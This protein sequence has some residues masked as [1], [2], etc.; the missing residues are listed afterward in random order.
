M[1]SSRCIYLTAGEHTP[2]EKVR[3]QTKEILLLMETLQLQL[4]LQ[5][6]YLHLH[7]DLVYSSCGWCC[8]CFHWL[9][10]EDMRHYTYQVTLGSPDRQAQVHTPDF[11]LPAE[12]TINCSL[13]APHSHSFQH[14]GYCTRVT[15]QTKAEWKPDIMSTGKKSPCPSLTRG[16]H[17]SSLL[18]E[19]M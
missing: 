16:L 7:V 6:L 2:A 4:Q 10:P 13:F 15:P 11:P 3:T 18:N 12:P 19:V 17:F 9:F 5:L 8:E 1:I 14:H